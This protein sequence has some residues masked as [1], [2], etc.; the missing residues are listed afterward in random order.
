MNVRIFIVALTGAIAQ[1]IALTTPSATAASGMFSD[2]GHV[3]FSF[4]LFLQGSAA[5]V[6][7]RRSSTRVALQRGV[8]LAFVLLLAVAALPSLANTKAVTA[9]NTEKTATT[10]GD[11]PW[12]NRSDEDFNAQAK[13]LITKFD[14]PAFA[15]LLRVSAE[16]GT[17]VAL[18]HIPQ[19]LQRAKSDISRGHTLAHALGVFS[20]QVYPTVGEAFGH[21]RIIFNFGC[22]HGVTEA[23]LHKLSDPQPSDVALLC[24]QYFDAEKTRRVGSGCWHGLGHG[25]TTTLNYDM[26]KALLY[27]AALVEIFRHTCYDGALMEM[28][29]ADGKSIQGFIRPNDPHYPCNVLAAEYLRACY[30]AQPKTYET[31][32]PGDWEA[33]AKLCAEVPAAYHA[34]CYEGIGRYLGLLTPSITDAVAKCSVVDPKHLDVCRMGA[35]S[36]DPTG[37]DRTLIPGFCTQMRQTDVI[38]RCYSSLVNRLNSE[39]VSQSDRLAECA[40]IEQPHRSRCEEQ[41]RN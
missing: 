16:Q 9:P 34:A 39:G 19:T 1:L 24:E 38:R 29:D 23:Y 33:A 8:T 5:L 13:K 36:A 20:V 18:T 2:S 15:A 21:C 41:V 7:L 22:F 40:R 4:G 14:I 32:H 37:F 6:V 26:D 31:F 12:A 25:L 3:L 27:C 10:T 35:I 30:M 11:Y 28:R 17:E